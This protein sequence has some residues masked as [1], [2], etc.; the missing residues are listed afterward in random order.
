MIQRKR[1]HCYKKYLDPRK[2]SCTKKYLD[3]HHRHLTWIEKLNT[4]VQATARD[5]TLTPGSCCTTLQ[6]QQSHILILA[7]P[8]VTRARCI[9]RP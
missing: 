6:L 4:E 9:V 1:F 2:K 5:G 3:K 7:D 8:R